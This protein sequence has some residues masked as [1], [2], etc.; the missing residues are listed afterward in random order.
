VPTV[1][2]A[3]KEAKDNLDNLSKSMEALMFAIYF[4]VITSM[5]DAEIVMAL[6]GD[7][8]ALLAQYRFGVEQALA[9]ADFLS[10]TEIVT[11]Q[12]LVIFLVCVRRHDQTRFVW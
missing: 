5:N 9:R 6:Q 11:V 8:M 7:K 4:A 12:A 1:T 10:S 2:K 3:I